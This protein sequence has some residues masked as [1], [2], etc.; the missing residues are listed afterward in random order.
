MDDWT[1]V[2][3]VVAPEQAD[4]AADL[5]WTSG[6]AAIEEQEVPEGV[7]LLAGYATAEAAD[8][9]A[10]A[11]DATGWAVSPAR[12]LP[13]TDDGLDGWR[14]WARVERAGPFL[15]TPTW[16][17][18][19]EVGAGERVLRLDPRRS[20]GS[21]SHPTSRLVLAQLA[22]LVGP[23]T[24]VL[25]VGTGSGVLA[26]GAA[27]LGA[28]RVVAID[29]DADSPATVAANA[30]V[31]EVATGTIDPSDLSL[32]DVV[33]TGEAF[34]VVAANLLAPVVVELAGDLVRA[35]APDGRLVVSGLLADRWA[36]T[37]EHLSALTVVAVDE[38]DGWVSVVLRRPA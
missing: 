8:R 5:L 35:T 36:A 18:E 1:R 3:V 19:P 4:L 17:D 2:A 34:D 27:L 28:P 22:D 24:S 31:N 14:A 11:L 10:A 7:L 38:Q 37:T 25:D 15:L 32:A 26:V 29:V 33:A 16:I 21:G 9:A 30:A 20:F 13:V 12:L 23:T 6:P